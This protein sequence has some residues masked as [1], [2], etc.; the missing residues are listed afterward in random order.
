VNHMN[1]KL[2][3]ILI[4]VVVIAS[5]IA[6]NEYNVSQEFSGTIKVSGAFA[7]YPLMVTWAQEYE[8]LH[9]KVKIEVSAGGAGK[10]MADALSGL[11]DLGMVS[12]EIK[13]EEVA[14]GAVYVAVTEDAVVCTISASNPVLNDILAKGVTKQMFYDIFIAGNVTT[15]GQ[16]VGR[17]DVSDPIHL[18]TRS[19]A[20]GAADVWAIYLGKKGQADLK[21]IGVYGD[22]GIVEALKT[23]PDGI[24]YNNI[25]YA[26]DANTT[27]QVTGIRVVPI[28]VN[29]NGQL[30]TNESFYATKTQIV[31][32]I[33]QGQYP[34]PPARKLYLV[35]KNKFTGVTKEFVKWILTDG[36]GFVS[37]A[38]YV[39]LASDIINAQIAK[40][41]S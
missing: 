38:G 7:L 12:R 16:V 20:A 14:Q 22:P 40:L 31:Q 2:V 15:W 28:D 5:L 41:Q 36:Q 33:G 10:G 26:Y 13:P 18:Y 25:G 34:S 1:K 8:K 37:P 21:G 4:V 3:G 39:P 35:T 32:A 6:Y 29:G 9:P 17:P 27:Q 30:D 11:V 23:D 24:G 19:D